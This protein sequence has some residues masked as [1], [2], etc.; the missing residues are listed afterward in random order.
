MET[1]MNLTKSQKAVEAA[2]DE[3]QRLWFPLCE[4]DGIPP[5]SKFVQISQTN[6]L[7]AEYEAAVAKLLAAVR[8]E[9]K[10]AARRARHEA[11]TSAGMK[12]VRGS[13]GGVYYE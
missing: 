3:V 10:N 7:R 1:P 13:L 6:P 2:R 12:R 8:V 11:Y 4:A 5:S 9:R